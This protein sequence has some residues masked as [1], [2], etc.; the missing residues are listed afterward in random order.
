MKT[1]K[2]FLITIITLIIALSFLGC[3]KQRIKKEIIQ[4][5]KEYYEIAQQIIEKSNKFNEELKELEKKDPGMMTVEVTEKLIK[6]LEK[7]NEDYSDYINKFR[8]LHI[9]E[10][11]DDFY[12]KKLEQFDNYYKA[13]VKWI[14][15]IE[16]R[17]QFLQY[18]DYTV[19]YEVSEYIAKETLEDL[20]D[21]NDDFKDLLNKSDE[22]FDKAYQFSMECS[23]I[24]REVYREFSLDDLID[25]WQQ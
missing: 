9:P 21:L 10:P 14:E 18:L 23:K 4:F 22:Y 12:Y 24:Q 2:I 25:K 3:E 8:N 6:L 11:L 13:H 16:S 20:E 7:S 19:D 17:K 15:A 5:D 1:Y